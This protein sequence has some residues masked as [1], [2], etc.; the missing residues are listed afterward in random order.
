MSVA[1]VHSAL[2]WALVG[3][4]LD[5]DPATVLDQDALV[6]QLAEHGWNAAAIREHAVACHAREEVWPHQVPP[7]LRAGLGAAQWFA[8]L[9]ELRDRLDVVVLEE[10]PPSTRT[11]LN[12]DERRLLAD[13]PPHFG[14]C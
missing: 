11:Q 2:A 12:A 6:T 7:E 9:G 1:N 3:E 10:R 4:Q 13:V 14:R 8:A 5:L